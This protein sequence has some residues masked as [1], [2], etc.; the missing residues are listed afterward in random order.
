MIKKYIDRCNNRLWNFSLENVK[1]IRLLGFKFLRTI[2]LSF[3]GFVE[4]S[5]RLKA[6]ALT[7]FT[8]LSVVP[9]L[10]MA[11]GVAK[12]FG[13]ENILK[14]ELLKNLPG[15]EAILQKMITY[16]YTLLATTGGGLIACVGI[17]VLFWTVIKLLGN[18][19]LSFN[20]IWG[21]KKNRTLGRKFSDYL[22]VMLLCPFLFI[23]SSSLM[24]FVNSQ[25]VGL[26]ARFE[27]IS[28]FGEYV[29]VLFKF[30]SFAILWVV[31]A[32]IYMF[33]PNTKVKV[34]SAATGGLLA[35]FAY[36]V[37]QQV[38]IRFQLG[39][40]SY[41]A[42]YGSFAILP[43]FLVW[44]Q[45]SWYIVLYG[46][47]VS[48][49]V[50]NMDMYEF[51]SECRNISRRKKEAVILGVLSFLLKH[52][53][54]ENLTSSADIAFGMKLP[55]RLVRDVIDELLKAKLIMEVLDE[56]EHVGHKIQCSAGEMTI[57]DILH[58]L[59]KAGDKGEL[60]LGQVEHY[61]DDI[62]SFYEDMHTPTNNKK[63]SQL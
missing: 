43:F 46:A 24:V 45:M 3:R 48:F 8:L 61:M 38:Y 12:G 26:F 57:S 22:S 25:I 6:S 19:E 15:Q 29:R 49:A 55:I 1:G 10:A 39:L 47:E 21:V 60:A 35:S 63:L 5:C 30:S 44:L 17:V 50:Q 13:V 51:E 41:N 14:N 28:Y 20:D 59:H 62:N 56:N 37:L 31:F 53:K 16:A 23:L 36:F 7:F 33:M 42:I 52:D 18:I 34:I 27:T 32:F 58:A 4:D 40:S 54:E 2:H 11:F 9:V